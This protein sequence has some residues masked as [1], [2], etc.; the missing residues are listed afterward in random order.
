MRRGK[1][2]R[3]RIGTGQAPGAQRRRCAMKMLTPRL[4]FPTLSSAPIAKGFWSKKE[5][6]KELCFML[7]TLWRLSQ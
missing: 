5:K 3:G 7:V 4:L 1:L 6:E 2:P